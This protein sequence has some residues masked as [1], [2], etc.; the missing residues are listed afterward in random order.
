MSG[1]EVS[2]VRIAKVQI[3]SAFIAG[4][5]ALVLASG[6]TFKKAELGSAS[7]PIKL[8]FV[9]SVDAK[10]IDS[11]SKIM[12]EWLEANT[13][14]KYSINVPQSYIAV[15]EAFGAKGA[16]VAAMNT[17]GYIKANE[18]YGAEARLIVLRHGK[19]TYQSQ[20]IAKK[21]RFKSLNDLNG[22]KVAFVDAASMSGYI[23]PLKMLADAGIKLGGDP[24]F[25]MKHDSVVSMVYQGQVDAGATF[26]SPPDEKEG[27]QDARRLVRTQYPD[28]E[29]KVEIIKLTEEIPN[30]PIVF[31][32][33]LPEDVKKTITEAFLKMVQTDQGREAF[34]AV[35]GV[36]A[37]ELATD[38]DYDSVREMLAKLNKSADDL[39]GKK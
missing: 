31:R 2:K 23:L 4:L 16:D 35:Y 8:F 32:K 3:A 29:E 26:Y 20:F 5:A 1:T 36:T 30:D 19:K 38:K 27:I 22:K 9:P 28:V 17:S 25:A 15:I 18:K 37:I 33:D 12:K 10:V 13:P 39:M 6:C 11:N 21:G 24:V 34:K 14:Y 7:N